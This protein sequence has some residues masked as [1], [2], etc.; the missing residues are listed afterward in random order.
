MCHS[1]SLESYI[2]GHLR[3]FHPLVVLSSAVM[4][5]H[6]NVFEFLIQMLLG[7]YLRAKLLGFTVLFSLNFGVMAKLLSRVAEPLYIPIVN[8]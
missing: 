3:C 2:D 8:M 5:V 6:V 1:L 4:N 7:K